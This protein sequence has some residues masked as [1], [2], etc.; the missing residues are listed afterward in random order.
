MDINKLSGAQL[1]KLIADFYPDDPTPTADKLDTVLTYLDPIMYY[2]KYYKIKGNSYVA[3]VPDY[4]KQMAAAHR[5]WQMEILREATNVNRKEVT[6]LKSRQL[7][8][9]E[10]GVM[11]LIYL[12]DTLSAEDL[13]FLYLFPKLISWGFNW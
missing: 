1:T 12:M 6:V 5:D 4:N 3:S 11:T 2:L 7:G 8:I 10:V 9:S 13:K